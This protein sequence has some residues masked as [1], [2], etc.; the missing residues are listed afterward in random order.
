M[1]ELARP[2][3]VPP[4]DPALRGQPVTSPVT[5]EQL[6]QNGKIIGAIA[7]FVLAV[8]VPSVIYL[9]RLSTNVEN[10]QTDVKDIKNKTEKLSLD[11]EG[12]KVRLETIEKR[13]PVP[14]ESKAPPTRKP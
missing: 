11:M 4:I 12:S 2:E 7:T 8:V 5:W 13:L 10:V 3:K 14:T 9:T 1:T 6:K